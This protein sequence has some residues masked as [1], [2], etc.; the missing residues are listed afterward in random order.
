VSSN[1]KKG[2]GT[3]ESN[4]KKKDLTPDTNGGQTLQAITA[5]EARGPHGNQAKGQGPGKGSLRFTR[6]SETKTNRRQS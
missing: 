3:R 4:T 6:E 2:K 5:E 1:N